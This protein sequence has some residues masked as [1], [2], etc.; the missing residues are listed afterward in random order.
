V[1]QPSEANNNDRLVRQR[2]RANV[3]YLYDRLL[4]NS[5]RQ[6]KSTEFC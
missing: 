1:P 4:H 3:K 6:Q 2:W 5:I